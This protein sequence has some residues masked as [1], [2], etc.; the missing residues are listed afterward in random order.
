M[1]P[2]LTP[3]NLNYRIVDAFAALPFNR[4]GDVYSGLVLVVALRAQY[5]PDTYEMFSHSSQLILTWETGIV[6]LIGR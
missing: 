1:I 5:L 4:S 2:T 3:N 6:L